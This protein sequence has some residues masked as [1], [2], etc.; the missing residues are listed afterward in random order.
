MLIYDGSSTKNLVNYPPAE[1]TR[2]M[3]SPLWDEYEPEYEDICQ[4][5]TIGKDLTFK[6]ETKD[7]DINTFINNPNSASHPI[8]QL[9]EG[10]MSCN[11]EENIVSVTKNEGIL[12]KVVHNSIPF[13]IDT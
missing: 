9:L 2:T 3:E 5:L 11:T 1:P 6:Y 13:D 4:I 8:Q 7:V 12:T 10:V